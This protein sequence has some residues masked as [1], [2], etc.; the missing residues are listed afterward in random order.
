MDF[1]NF[2]KTLMTDSSLLKTVKLRCLHL[3]KA[4]AIAITWT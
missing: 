4:T 3:L 1:Y 2:A